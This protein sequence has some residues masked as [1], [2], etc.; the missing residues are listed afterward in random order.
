MG[1]A[2]HGKLLTNSFPSSM[3]FCAKIQTKLRKDHIP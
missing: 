3:S 2:M 1:P